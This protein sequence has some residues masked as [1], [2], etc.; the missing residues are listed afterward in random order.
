M[1]RA[2]YVGLRVQALAQGE[3]FQ[4]VAAIDHAP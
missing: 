1:H 2:R 4:I 3:V